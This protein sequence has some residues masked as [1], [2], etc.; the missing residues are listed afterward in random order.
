MRGRVQGQSQTANVS[1]GLDTEIKLLLSE[2][3]KEDID[4]ILLM[5]QSAAGKVEKHG[6]QT[7]YGFAA[8]PY[9]SCWLA[10]GLCIWTVVI[11]DLL[12]HLSVK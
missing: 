9:I 7:F 4:V 8:L 11:G 2:A 6:E 10:A 3:D 12:T 5:Q 1:P